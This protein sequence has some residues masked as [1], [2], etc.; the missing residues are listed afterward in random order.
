[1]KSG[2]DPTHTFAKTATRSV[3]QYMQPLGD[4]VAL[5]GKR[6]ISPREIFS[7]EYTSKGNNPDMVAI[8]KLFGECKETKTPFCLFACSN[9]PHSPW[10]KG[11]ASRYDPAA[12]KLPPYFVDTPETR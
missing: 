8:D 2:A 3:V 4:R 10:N 5:S 7:F 11:D 9:E 1:M 6:H 12:I